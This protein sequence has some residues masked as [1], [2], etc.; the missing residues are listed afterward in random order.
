VF[1][2]SLLARTQP[3]DPAPMMMVSKLFIGAS[4]HQDYNVHHKKK[5]RVMR[6]FGLGDIVAINLPCG[7]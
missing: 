1:A 7:L 4:E 2:P 3:A 5:A 6:A